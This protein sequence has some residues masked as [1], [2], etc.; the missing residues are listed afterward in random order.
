MDN[1][2]HKDVINIIGDLISNDN[3]IIADI[4]SEEWREVVTNEGLT[5]R[6]P[7]P[8]T[9]IIRKGGSTHRVINT[10]GE[11]WCYVA[12]ETGKSVIKWK[13]DPLITF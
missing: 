1:L 4:S 6:I 3:Y 11:V 10:N 7:K 13:A 8:V 5:F 2:T 9:L 12:P